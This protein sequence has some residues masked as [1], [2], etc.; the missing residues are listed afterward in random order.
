MSINAA[1]FPASLWDGLSINRDSR[2]QDAGPDYEDWDQIVAEV[3]AV[4][5]YLIGAQTSAGFGAAAGTGVTADTV[6]G[7][8][9]VTTIDI[10]DLAL[11][12]TD[13]GTIASGSQKIYDFPAGNI[14][15]LGAVGLLSIVAGA[16]GLTDTAAVVMS[17]GTVAAAAD[18]TLTSTEAN[19]IPSTTATLS[20]G[21][22]AAVDMA[23]TAQLIADGTA[24]AI[25]AYLNVGVPD[26]GTSASDTL[27][28]NGSITITWVNLGDN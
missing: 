4:Q 1:E 28:V 17:V 16:G 26:A 3:L 9:N 13:N 14:L 23:S 15:V 19:I 24:T 20:G 5:D 12:T 10:A 11:A 21:E 7:T 25:D 2:R 27:T 18:A 22:N 8:L 6:R